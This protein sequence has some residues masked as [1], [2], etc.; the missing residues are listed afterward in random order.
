[1][2]RLIASFIDMFICFIILVLL[3][4][5]FAIFQRM[6]LNTK[7]IQ[8]IYDPMDFLLAPQAAMAAFLL[9]CLLYYLWAN[10]KMR[11]ITV[12]KKITGI[13]VEEI[14]IGKGWVVCHIILREI[15]ILFYPIT[16]IYFLFFGKMPYDKIL[17]LRVMNDKIFNNRFVVWINRVIGSGLVIGIVFFYSIIQYEVILIPYIIPYVGW[18]EADIIAGTYAAAIDLPVSYVGEKVVNCQDDSEMYGYIFSEEGRKRNWAF[19]VVDQ[20]QYNEEYELH[21]YGIDELQYFNFEDDFL[22]CTFGRKLKSVRIMEGRD[23]FC[24]YPLLEL[25]QEY[26]DG[27]IYY[28]CIPRIKVE[29]PDRCPMQLGYCGKLL[30]NRTNYDMFMG[31]EVES[32]V[33]ETKGPLGRWIWAYQMEFKRLY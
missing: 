8:R 6:I 7:A 22:V 3:R 29:A 28:Y 13:T 1:M 27:T 15:A 31:Y 16:L 30:V 18:A 4:L 24:I 26:V 14:W 19:T 9:V 23:E 17:G 5:I 20:K 33:L 11:G 21:G 25:G 12:G 10:K 2:K 32:P